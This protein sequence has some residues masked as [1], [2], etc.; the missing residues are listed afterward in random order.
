[1]ANILVIENDEELAN[2]ITFALT[3]AGF[4]VTIAGSTCEGLGEL[5]K[6][7]PDVII[8]DSQLAEAEKGEALL[9]VRQTSFLPILVL[10]KREDAAEYLESGADAFMSKPMVIRELLARIRNLLIRTSKFNSRKNRTTGIKGPDGHT[11]TNN[12][13]GSY[14]DDITDYR[15]YRYR[16]VREINQENLN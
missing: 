3:N 11:F 6:S 1:M 9:K 2:S 16:L 5:F 15:G 4:T 12:S 8:M 7:Y 10:G 14:T 13:R